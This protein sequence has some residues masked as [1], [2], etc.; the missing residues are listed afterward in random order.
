MQSYFTYGV[1]DLSWADE[2]I[3]TASVGNAKHRTMQSY[4]TSWA[5]ERTGI[6]DVINAKHTFIIKFKLEANLAW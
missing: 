4:F 6:Y 2:R 1:V 3:G 5:D